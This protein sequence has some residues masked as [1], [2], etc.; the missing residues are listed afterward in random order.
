MNKYLFTALALLILFSGCFSPWQSDKAVITISLGR[1]SIARSAAYPPTELM[2]DEMVYVIILS[3]PGPTL[4]LPVVG[5]G[6]HSVTVIPGYWYVNVSASYLGELYA[7]GSNSGEVK[8][9]QNNPIP[10]KIG[11]NHIWSDWTAAT[12]PAA[13]DYIG[14]EV[15]E[16]MRAGCAVSAI[17]PFTY[18]L[19]DTG[20]GGGIIFYVADGKGGRPLNFTVEGDG[21]L[22]E[23]YIAR[24]LEA[25]PEDLHNLTWA[26]SSLLI[27]GL[28]QSESDETDW[29]IGRG[30][31]NT[32][33]IIAHGINHV[34]PYSTTAASECVVYGGGGINDWFLPSKDEVYAFYQSRDRYGIPDLGD[35]LTSSQL[36]LELAWAQSF[37]DG[38]QY[39][40]YKHY[41]SILV[42]P[43]RAF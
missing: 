23:S 5:A 40:Y 39:N 21:V 29:A 2:L 32:A 6:T 1:N 27:P 9:G 11:C 8:A 30:R 38:S 4:E 41:L 37:Y 10:I 20:P 22:L 13:P 34:P 24:Y 33:I 15:R 3:G 36:D 25:A 12:I 31:L 19:G 28:S 42:R 7:V 16:C 43:V 35:F 17:R 14:E 26:D 18:S